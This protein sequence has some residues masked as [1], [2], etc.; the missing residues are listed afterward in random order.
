MKTKKL[1][2]TNDELSDIEFAL[3]TTYCRIE[4]KLDNPLYD[5]LREL[6]DKVRNYLRPQK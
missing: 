2:F 4:D 3:L 1:T 5:A 6:H